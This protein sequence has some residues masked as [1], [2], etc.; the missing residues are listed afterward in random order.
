[1]DT[2]GKPAYDGRASGGALPARLFLLHCLPANIAPAETF[3]PFD[4]VDRRVGALPRLYHRLARSRDVEHAAAIGENSA[5][6]GDRA[7]LED[8]DA[9]DLR[10]L[11]QPLD[12]APLGIVAGIAF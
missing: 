7:S 5:V 8:F 1:M 9:L 2:R 12:A 6:P 11:F 4:P 10:R 3:R